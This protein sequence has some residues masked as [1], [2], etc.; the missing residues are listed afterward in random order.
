ME[1][2]TILFNTKQKWVDNIVGRILVQNKIYNLWMLNVVVHCPVCYTYMRIY[3]HTCTCNGRHRWVR[4]LVCEFGFVC[5]WVRERETWIWWLGA[6]PYVMLMRD[7]ISNPS[8][9]GQILIFVFRSFV[10]RHRSHYQFIRLSQ[11]HIWL[12]PFFSSL[13]WEF[14]FSAFAFCSH[15]ND[16]C[17]RWWN[18]YYESM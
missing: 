9:D 14:L 4:V 5:E 15:L 8:Y 6:G 18:F 12:I 3:A 7:F 13:I 1:I 2:K 10:F 11:S 17:I 16:S